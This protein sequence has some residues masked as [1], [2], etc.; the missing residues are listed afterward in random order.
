MEQ[1]V[2]VRS[3]EASTSVLVPDSGNTVPV[4]IADEYIRLFRVG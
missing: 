4:T 1:A 2:G 3:S